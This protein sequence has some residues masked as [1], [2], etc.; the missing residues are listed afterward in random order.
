VFP[1]LVMA[2][3]LLAHAAIHASFIAPRPPAVD[4]P[5]WPFDLSRSWILGPMGLGGAA[6]RLLGLAL[7]AT[8][9]GGFAFA[10]LAAVGIA[11]TGAWAPALVLGAVA[12]VVLIAT[13]FHPWLVL[14]IVIDAVLIWA[15]LV[16]KWTPDTL[17]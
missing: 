17:P 11:P 3:F 4:G 7:I 6:T 1:K 12:S 5:A 2:A 15:V 8:T 14:G 13:F 16:A 9:I 10:A